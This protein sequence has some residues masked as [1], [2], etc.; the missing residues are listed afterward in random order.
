MLDLCEIRCFLSEADQ[1]LVTNG[2]LVYCLGIKI[3]VIRAKTLCMKSQIDSR[4]G[5]AGV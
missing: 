5:T 1:E 3:T 2:R 4:F